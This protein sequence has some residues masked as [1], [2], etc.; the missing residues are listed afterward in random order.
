MQQLIFEIVFSA[1]G[2]ALLT[3]CGYKMFQIYQLSSYK[4][5]GVFEWFKATRFDYAARYFSLAFLSFIGMFVYIGCFGQRESIKYIGSVVFVIFAV[6]FIIVTA[7][8]RKKTPL[9][10]TPR[11]MRCITL[12]AVM[13]VAIMYGLLRLGRLCAPSYALTAIA[14]LIIPFATA[15]AHIVMLPFEKMNNAGYKRRAERVLASMPELKRIGITG[16]YGKTS[17]KNILAQML[18]KKYKAAFSPSSYNTPMGLSRF[19]NSELKPTDE[20]LI[21]EMGARNIGDIEELCKMIR[22]EYGLITSIGNQHLETFGSIENVMKAKFELAENIADGGKVVFNGD[23]DETKELFGRCSSDKYLVGE[24]D[25]PQACAYY[26]DVKIGARGTEFVMNTGDAEINVTTRLLGKHVAGLITSCAVIARLLGV[27]SDDIVAA[28]AEIEPVPH[29]LQLIDR[30]ETI[31]IDDAYNA[32]VQGSKNALEVLGKFEDRVKIIVTPGLVELG[33]EESAANEEFGK[34]IAE[35]AD[36]AFLIGA[37]AECMKKGALGGGMK[38]ENVF[39]LKS[40][41]E[42]VEKL[43]DIVGKKVV[44]FENDLPDNY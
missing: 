35:N 28:C 18:K 26:K 23:C 19:I 11:V 34:A 20:I 13:N 1:V 42:S 24:K 16:S 2:A 40:L 39:V 9:K 12:Y 25:L 10:F 22:P 44:L 4:T 30:G 27:S 6:V 3:M 29:R 32:N 21:A 33:E 31:V 41:D 15:F 8:E 7:K 36:Y 14:A 37:R 43:Q 5:K 38:E 17:A